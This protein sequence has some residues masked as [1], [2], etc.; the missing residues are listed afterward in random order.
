LENKVFDITD[1]RCNHE[2]HL[3]PLFANAQLTSSTASLIWSTPEQTNK[4]TDTNS[5]LRKQWNCYG[6]DV[7]VQLNCELSEA[8]QIDR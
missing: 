2:V 4:Q 7:V 1:A 8:P 5:E 3:I 6:C